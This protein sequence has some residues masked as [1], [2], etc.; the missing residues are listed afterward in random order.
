MH[1][2]ARCGEHGSIGQ[3]L[4]DELQAEQAIVDAGEP[5]PGD[6][7][8]VDLDAF[9]R[10]VFQE[11]SDQPWQIL[12]MEKRAKDQVDAERAERLLLVHRALVEQVDVHDD[13]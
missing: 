11:R 7:D 3:S 6:L 9:A 10:Q 1:Y 4:L 2:L 5:G 12:S 13:L 8:H